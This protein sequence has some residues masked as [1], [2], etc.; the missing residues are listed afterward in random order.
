[1]KKAWNVCDFIFRHLCIGPWGEMVSLVKNGLGDTFYS[2]PS[3]ASVGLDFKFCIAPIW[4]IC[5]VSAYSR[6][7]RRI[8]SDIKLG[9]KSGCQRDN[10]TRCGRTA[11]TGSGS[12]VSK[13]VNAFWAELSW[14]ELMIPITS[15]SM[16]SERE[17]SSCKNWAEKY[18]VL[19]VE[20]RLH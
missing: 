2:S 7:L 5:R 14:T 4:V 10:K 16:G 13:V 1:M 11:K 12:H 9:Y 6:A 19:I 17:G 8:S 20:K 15:I 3:I 18:E